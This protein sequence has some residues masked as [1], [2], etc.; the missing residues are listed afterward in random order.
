MSETINQCDPHDKKL[1]AQCPI[2]ISLKRKEEKAIV[3]CLHIAKKTIDNMHPTEYEVHTI[4]QKEIRDIEKQVRGKLKNGAFEGWHTIE[5]T[6][7]EV[8][9]I[10]H[11]L[12][13][14]L[15]SDHRKQEKRHIRVSELLTH[16]TN[17]HN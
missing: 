3:E 14:M 10:E 1:K 6:A 4:T 5:L 8:Q 9:A 17:P 12:T 15:F 7:K 2:K 13:D 11:G 16:H